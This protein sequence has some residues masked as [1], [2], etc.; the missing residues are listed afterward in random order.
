M[1]PKMIFGDNQI[2]EHFML[3]VDAFRQLGAGGPLRMVFDPTQ[4]KTFDAFGRDLRTEISHVK[5]HEHGLTSGGRL[6][7]AE[8]TLHAPK[9]EPALTS[10]LTISE[11]HLWV[12]EVWS[13]LEVI[14]RRR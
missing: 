2:R 1:H 13:L 5:M 12:H 4:K 3:P 11:Y 7:R 9:D 10:D 8:T 14:V 6:L